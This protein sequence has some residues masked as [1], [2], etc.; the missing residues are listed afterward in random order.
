[1]GIL[2]FSLY[3]ENSLSS[4]SAPPRPYFGPVN[5]LTFSIQLMD[6]YGRIINLNNMDYSI[7]M[8]LT[9]IYDL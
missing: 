5:L 7:C 8:V 6:E 1:M 3:I 2:N 9:C 4:T